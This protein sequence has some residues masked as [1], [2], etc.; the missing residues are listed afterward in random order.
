MKD[1]KYHKVG[2]HYHY[3]EEYR[4]P[5]YGICSLKY[6]VPKKIHIACHNGSNYDNHLAEEFKSNP[7]V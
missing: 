7:L 1:K 5:A 6:N 2:D 4:G 3:G